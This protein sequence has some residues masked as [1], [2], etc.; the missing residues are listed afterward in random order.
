MKDIMTTE[1]LAKKWKMNP[2]SLANWRS[3]KK[4][5]KFVKLGRK[6]RYKLKDIE[7]FE[8]SSGGSRSLG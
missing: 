1:E 7:R 8:K 2:G 4:G 5:P 3:E 6:V